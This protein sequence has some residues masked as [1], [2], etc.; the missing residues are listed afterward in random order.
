[1]AGQ[2]NSKWWV[3]HSGTSKLP[4]L[5]QGFRIR[6]YAGKSVRRDRSPSARAPRLRAPEG[7]CRW[8]VVTWDHY[9][10]SNRH[11]ATML[12]RIPA[13]L[14]RGDSQVSMGERV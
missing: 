5:F 12:E 8:L 1:V 9:W 7:K 14:N 13:G 11:L 10:N 2:W 4:D 6:R 3:R